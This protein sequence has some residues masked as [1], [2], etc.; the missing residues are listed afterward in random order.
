M[1][2]IEAKKQYKKICNELLFHKKK[3]HSDD[4][5]EIEDDEYDVLKRKV[6][7][8]EKNFPSLKKNDSPLDLIGSALSSSFEKVL[9]STKIESLHDSFSNEEISE[10]LS[11]VSKTVAKTQWIV[12]PKIDG[13]SIVVK[14]EDGV[15]THALTRG[16][17]TIG[18][19]IT[20]NAMRINNLPKKINCKAKNLEIR[21][22]VFMPKK[23]FADLI[24]SSQGACRFKNP[25]NAA[26]GLLRGMGNY[27]YE[28]SRLEIVFFNVQL[29]EIL[30]GRFVSPGSFFGKIPFSMHKESLDFVSHFGF[31]VPPLSFVCTDYAEICSAIEKI[32]KKRN[33]FAFGID[34]AVIKLNNLKERAIL[35]ST[36]STPRWAEAFKYVPEEKI[37]RLGRIELQVGRTGM[38]TPVG[39]FDPIKLGGTS[40]GGAKIS[41]LGGIFGKSLQAGAVVNKAT[42]HNFD[43]IRL[44]DIRVGDMVA[45]RKAGDIIPEIVRAIKNKNHDELNVFS[46]PKK[47]PGCGC[48]ISKKN[49]EV[50]YYCVN[51][52]CFER[53]C[54]AI[55]HFVSRDAMDIKF[56]G[57]KTI[58]KLVGA[59]LLKNI[60][61]IYKLTRENLAK[62][63]ISAF[64]KVGCDQIDFGFGNRFKKPTRNFI[65]EIENSK[66][67]PLSNFIYA[68]GIP[69][70]GKEI[71]RL[72]AERFGEYRKLINANEDEIIKI[73]GIGEICARSV[74]DFFSKN[75]FSIFEEINFKSLKKKNHNGT[76]SDKIFVFTGTLKNF[77]RNDVKNEVKLRGGKIASDI[78]TKTDFLVCGEK[79]GS[80]FSKAKKLGIK[81]LDEQEFIK[82]I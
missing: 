41:S 36:S 15:L 8:L 46:V 71:A 80:K 68:L 47:C 21:G 20:K 59:G 16:D 74:V 81:T 66:K 49:E 9:H 35:G 13:L 34:G 43:N 12:E 2:F 14:Y 76:F 25:R 69:W 17:G 78:N 37:T 72:L 22:E 18:E 55:S 31:P 38:I 82:M 73:D 7:D 50:A 57:E 63:D 4:F 30:D 62:A 32:S 40:S 1:N 64:G 54:G 11:R 56:L 79:P 24:E 44:K 67:K 60:S 70:V 51:P 53:V 6:E 3:L 19:D 26:A 61:D 52:N 27:S 10:F 33:D 28:A 58:R 29:F 23:V 77:T 48:D 39:V 45:V 5:P 65:E 75:K 42:L